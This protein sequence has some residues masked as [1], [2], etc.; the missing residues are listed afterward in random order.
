M[1]VAF[2]LCLITDRRQTRGRSLVN[3]VEDALRGGVRA[4]QLR[5]KD[6]PKD[7][8]YRLAGELRRITSRHGARLLINGNADLARD[9]GADGVHLPENGSPVE[10][11]RKIIGPGR[12][13]GVSCHSLNAARTVEKSGANFITFGPIFSTLSKAAYGNPV[14]LAPLTETARILAIPVFGLGGINAGNAHQ[15]MEAGARGIALISAI[16]AA[17]HPQTAAATMLEIMR[18]SDCSDMRY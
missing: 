16:M 6:L 7:E 1:R 14:G 13:I 3:V 8:L 17:D 15:V 12:L 18:T 11:V 10:A 5:E 2:G 4:V 9:V